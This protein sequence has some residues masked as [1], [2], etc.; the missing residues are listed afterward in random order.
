MTASVVAVVRR[1]RNQPSN[2]TRIQ[3]GTNL[4]ALQAHYA[5]S[6]H[7]MDDQIDHSGAALTDAIPAHHQLDIIVTVYE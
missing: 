5:S 2:V 6:K 4:Q 1:V 7:Q 3:T